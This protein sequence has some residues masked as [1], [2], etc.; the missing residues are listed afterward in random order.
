[1]KQLRRMRAEEA[2]RLADAV[3]AGMGSGPGAEEWYTIKEAEAG[4]R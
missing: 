4:W 3:R 2:I 1:M